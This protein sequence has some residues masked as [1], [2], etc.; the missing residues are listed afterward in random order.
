MVNPIILGENSEEGVGGSHMPIV[1]MTPVKNLLRTFKHQS[2]FL[3]IWA[4]Y[5]PL[6]FQQFQSSDLSFSALRYI[7]SNIGIGAHLFP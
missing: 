4:E 7:S 1:N 2:G 6:C 5:F 3:H